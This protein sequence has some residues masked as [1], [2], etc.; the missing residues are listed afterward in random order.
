MH[1]YPPPCPVLIALLSPLV[2]YH[3]GSHPCLLFFFN[4]EIVQ[5]IMTSKGPRSKLDHDT[6]VRRQKG[7]EAPREPPR[8]K[9]HWDHVLEEM[10]W[11][12][13][14]FE[15]ERKWKLAQA[16]KI[17]FTSA[18][19]LVVID[20]LWISLH[21]C[22]KNK[23]WPVLYKHQ[24]ELDDKKRPWTNNLYLLGQIEKVKFKPI[25]SWYSTML[26]ENLL[27]TPDS[28]GPQRHCITEEKLSLQQKFSSKSSS[29]G[30]GES[31]ADK[32][33]DTAEVD[34]EFIIESEEEL[35]DDEQT[36]EEDEALITEEERQEELVALQ[37][38]VDLPLE[39]L[40]KRYSAD[41]GHLLVQIS[42]FCVVSLSSFF[43]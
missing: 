29:H 11:L 36:I 10:I 18:A 2:S 43:Y 5:Y 34:D 40:L 21:D 23:L 19:E 26:A 42:L 4:A 20:D 22:C 27:G 35:E 7:F 6:R 28:G 37:S 3:L 1:I 14:D 15:S 13:K 31:L 8:P 33:S 41:E 16:K 39:E 9:S 24:L 12:S 30:S 25:C 38:E 32:K 17:G